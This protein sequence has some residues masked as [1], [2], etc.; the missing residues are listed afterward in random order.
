MQRVEIDGVL[1]DL[2][3]ID[4]GVLQ[5]SILGPIL[6]LCFIND[7]HTIT[8]LLALLFADDTSL[9]ALGYNLHEL[10]A[11]CNLELHKIANWMIANKLAVNVSK[12]K[13]IIFHNKGKKID[14]GG[15]SI[16]FNMNEFNKAA[17]P[18][19]IIPLDRI[20]NTNPNLND[21]TYKYLGVLL[22][23][24]FTLNS[25]F[26]YI[27]NKLSKGLFC[28]NRA[29]NYLNSP[30]LKTLYFSL[31]HS[32]LLDCSLILN[33]TSNKNIKRV[34]KM[35]KKA[36]R[37]ISHASYN[38]HT[39]PLFLEHSILPF[40]KI[41]FYNKIKFIHGI[42]HGHI[43]RSF[44]NL[45][46]RNQN[47]ANNRDLRNNDDLNVPFPRYEG[48]KKFPLYDFPKSWNELGPMKYQSNSTTFKIWLKEEIF[49]QIA[50]LNLPQ[51]A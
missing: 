30:S 10:I 6:F 14:M 44:D 31:F 4:I 5:G 25:H 42:V 12:C 17:L 1:S 37:I 34:S 29:K 39:A 49:R 20:Y 45:L 36:I 28:L 24:N 21:R 48:F 16:N 19:K 22:D 32:H 18:E 2:A 7:L 13:F 50:S 51:L 47:M 27:C 26:D 3:S 23:E 46:N 8:D 35:Q 9:L 40:E 43:L 33:C 38:D 11:K 15:I 41:L